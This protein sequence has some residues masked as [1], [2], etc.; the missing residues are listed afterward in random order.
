MIWGLSITTATPSPVYVWFPGQLSDVLLACRDGLQMGSG[1]HAAVGWCDK[2]DSYRHPH[3]P[4]LQRRHSHRKDIRNGISASALV[5]MGLRQPMH[6]LHG[7]PREMAQHRRPRRVADLC[8]PTARD[9]LWHPAAR[10]VYTNAP[11]AVVHLIMSLRSS[12][13]VGDHLF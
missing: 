8:N 10:A 13:L 4:L 5:R 6:G 7:R 9:H 12:H 11:S 2:K 3:A 1:G